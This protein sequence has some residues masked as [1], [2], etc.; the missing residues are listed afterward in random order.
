[1]KFSFLVVAAM[2]ITCVNASGRGQPRSLFKKY[3]GMK[4][5]DSAQKLVID[6]DLES[7]PPQK[8]PRLGMGQRLLQSSLVRGFR[9]ALPYSSLEDD[10]ES[11]PSQNS[12][13]HGQEPEP[14]QSS[15]ENDSE[16]GS[17]QN[18]PVYKP[19]TPQNPE[20]KKGGGDGSSMHDP[21]E[22]LCSNLIAALKKS[23][24][25]MVKIVYPAKSQQLVSS[26]LNVKTKK[27]P[28][29][30][31]PTPE[32]EEM[33]REKR[34]AS[35]KEDYTKARKDFEINKCSTKYPDLLSQ[36]QLAEMDMLFYV[37]KYVSQA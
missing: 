6:D 37:G 27:S 12:P 9:S 36:K 13:E 26:S 3:G 10:P 21:I 28:S 14:S 11:G 1:M 23:H 15:L 19:D 20:P 35:L 17:S 2:V 30:H 7:E 29:Q 16:P 34:C 24:G 22:L 25:Q 4:R 18:P 33:E 5:S 8:S 31:Q 32:Q